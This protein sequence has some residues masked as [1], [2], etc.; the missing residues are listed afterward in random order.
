MPASVKTNNRH[1]EKSGSPKLP[2]PEDDDLIESYADLVNELRLLTTVS[3]LL[4]GFLLA[5]GPRPGSVTDTE[6]WMFFGA[7]IAAG[8]ATALFV[9]PSVYHHMQFPY[10]NWEKFQRRVHA[11]MMLGVPFL[12]AGFYLSLGI[13]VWDHV[14]EGAFIIAAIP[15]VVVTVVLLFRRE[16]TDGVN[17]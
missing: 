3:A 7:I 8:I 2:R 13:S 10:R 15:L 1:R 11:F 16:L 4:F 6:R 12:A 9:L 17:Q 5:L 14:Q